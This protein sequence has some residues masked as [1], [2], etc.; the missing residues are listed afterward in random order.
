MAYCI[1]VGLCIRF[2]I[3]GVTHQTRSIVHSQQISSA[4]DQHLLSLAILT[5]S[6]VDLDP[7]P[8]AYCHALG[9]YKMRGYTLITAQ[10]SEYTFDNPPSIVLFGTAWYT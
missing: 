10:S 2:S 1:L 6:L 5:A 7:V 3:L 4:R 8:R 9:L